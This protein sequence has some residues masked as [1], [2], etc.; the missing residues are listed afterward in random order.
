MA[1]QEK[2]PL[3][4]L[5][6][7]RGDLRLAGDV[8]TSA[9]AAHRDGLGLGPV[10]EEHART[11]GTH[12]R[13]VQ[14]PDLPVGAHIYQA[15]HALQQLRAGPAFVGDQRELVVCDWPAL[16]SDPGH[17]PGIGD[18]GSPR[19]IAITQARQDHG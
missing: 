3:Q 2:V 1:G 10:A 19:P 13:R 18:G 6:T 11:Q 16:S 12:E 7:Q 17:E 8:R 15:G 14:H 4:L 5:P 9:G